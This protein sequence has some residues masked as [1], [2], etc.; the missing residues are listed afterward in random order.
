MKKC[1]IVVVTYNR[2]ALLKENINS[3]LKQ[4]WNDFDLY[5]INNA[6]TD[7]TEEYIQSLKDKRIKYYNTGNNLGGAGGFSYGL[8][9]VLNCDYKYAWIMDDDSIPNKDALESLI[10]KAKDL[11]DN[12]S[13]LASLVYWTDNT[14]FPMNLPHIA[15]DNLEDMDCDIIRK[16]KLIKISS[17][18]FVGCFINLDCAQKAG[19]PIKEFFIYGD[20]VEY[21]MRISTLKQGYLDL[22]SIIIHKAPSKKGSDIVSSEEERIGRY[23]YQSRNRMYI[24]RK[25]K[26]LIKRLWSVLKTTF[27]IIL[28][29]KDYKFKRIWVLIS[30]TISGLWFNPTIEFNRG[31]NE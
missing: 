3:I 1:A 29:S 28:F 9:K 25:N 22:D 20:D 30:G 13:F 17:G 19:L 6:S 21:T 12:F 14:I 27:K 23:Y 5:I 4:S 11:E 15:Y 18:S 24:A 7:N 8:N 31:K 16:S 2:L 10:T 26:N